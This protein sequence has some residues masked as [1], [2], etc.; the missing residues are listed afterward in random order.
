M[1]INRVGE[2]DGLIYK[3]GSAVYDPLGNRIA[4]AGDQETLVLADVDLRHVDKV[5]SEM[6]FL[7]DRKF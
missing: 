1:G 5:R 2:G 3:G 6:P 7:R 4:F